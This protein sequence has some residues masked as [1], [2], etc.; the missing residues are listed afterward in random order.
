M[1]KASSAKP[2]TPTHVAHKMNPVGLVLWFTGAARLHKDG[3]GFNAV[4][5]WWHPATWVLMVAMVLPCALMGEP[6]LNVVA[7]RLTPFWRKHRAQI[8]WV[9]PFT[10]LDALKPFDYERRAHIR[11]AH[12]IALQNP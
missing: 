5:R 1:A 10:R 4:W 9:T 2:R 3:D 11:D 8:Q 6:L 7:L 12:A